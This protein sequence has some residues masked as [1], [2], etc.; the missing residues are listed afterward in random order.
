M[1]VLARAM[2]DLLGIG[3]QPKDLPFWQMAIRSVLVYAAGI[4]IVRIGPQRFLGRNSSFDALLGFII[5]SVLSR[6][7]NGSAPF[8]ETLGVCTV[9]VALH[10]LV[11]WLSFRFGGFGWLV[12]G[13]PIPLILHGHA[14]EAAMRR[15]TISRHDIVEALH[16]RALINDTGR[17]ESAFL[18]RNG[19]VSVVLKEQSPRILDVDVADG[20]KTVRIKLE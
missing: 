12:K 10:W 7:V 20:V 14:D 15:S 4:A 1:E 13:D 8:W 9:M 3:V 2:S 6:A 5:G 11:A 17:I 16:L 19:Q 18:E